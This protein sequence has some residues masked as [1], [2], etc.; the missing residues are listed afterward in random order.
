MKYRGTESTGQDIDSVLYYLSKALIHS[1]GEHELSAHN[2][3]D[4]DPNDA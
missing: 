2:N 4:Q 1:L 3:G